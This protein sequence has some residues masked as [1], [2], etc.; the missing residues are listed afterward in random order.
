[1]TAF[2]YTVRTAVRGYHVYQDIWTERVG[3]QFNCR[4][5][6]ENEKDRYAVAVYEDSEAAM[7]LDTFHEIY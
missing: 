1:M 7:C 2:M 6:P 5:E 3:N 4:Q